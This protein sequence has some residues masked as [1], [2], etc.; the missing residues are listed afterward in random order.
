MKPAARAPF[1]GLA[2]AAALLGGGASGAVAAQEEKDPEAKEAKPPLVCVN[3]RE[4]NVIR[5]LDGQH[6]FVQVSTRRYYMFTLDKTCVGFKLA[7]KIA[8]SDYGSRVC[9]DGSSLLSF[10][11]LVAG[12]MRCRI[13]RIDAVA[14]ADAARALIDERAAPE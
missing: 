3:R 7:R 4:I 6:A 1:L 14:D 12:P 8:L 10:E 13:E 9:G 2:V 5:A 11:D